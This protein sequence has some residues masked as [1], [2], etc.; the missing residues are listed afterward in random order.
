MPRGHTLGAEGAIQALRDL[1]DALPRCDQH[2]DRP[3][4]RAVV[5]G[6]TRYCDAC[7]TGVPEYP[8]ASPLRRAVALLRVL[9]R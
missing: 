8:R 9:G 7:G 2:P 4:T 1:V 6:S 3:D 5:R